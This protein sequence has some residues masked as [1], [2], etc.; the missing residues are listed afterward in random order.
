[1][2]LVHPG[3]QD[4]GAGR[5]RSNIGAVPSPANLERLARLLDAGTLSVP[6][7]ATYPLAQADQALK[8]LTTQHTQGKLSITLP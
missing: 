4:L 8:A 1:M 6:I 5:D 3:V 7:R 2:P